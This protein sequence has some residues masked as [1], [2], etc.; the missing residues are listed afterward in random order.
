MGDYYLWLKAAHVCAAIVFVGGVLASSIV[1]AV[2]PAIP[3]HGPHVAAVFRRYDRRVT[4]PAMVAVW[5]L[6]L[7]L[8]VSG[9][10]FGSLWVNGKLALVVILSGIHGYQSGK[11]RKIAA[12][13]G[14]EGRSTVPLVIVLTMAIA[15]FAVL[16][17]Q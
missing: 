15:F 3:R 13:A 4:V 17:P 8:A 11:L 12:G 7:S 10:W 14:G 5:C 6:G 1:Q 2:L 16:K 9:S